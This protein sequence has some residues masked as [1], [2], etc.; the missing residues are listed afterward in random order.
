MTDSINANVVVSMPSQLFTMARSFKAVANGKIYIGKIDTDPVNPENQIPV[1]V[2]NEDGSHVPVS[3]PI[4]INAAGYPV[5][6]GQI[7]KF[8]TV[9]G[10]SMAVYDAYGA[11]QFY[12]PNVLKYDPDQFR[13]IIESPEGAGH[14]GY[15]YRRNTGSTMRMVSD[16]LDERVSLWDFHC[17]S[18]GNVIQP[19]PTVDSR[20][21]IQKAIDA[22]YEDGGGT[23]IIPTGTWYL[24]SYG[25]PDKISNY[26][27]VIHWR[28]R[29]NIHFEAG[30]TLKLTNYFN[31]RGYCVICGFDG[32]D[33]ATSGDLRDAMITG[34]GTIHC[35]DN[36][37]AVGGS[38][39]YAIGTGRS[40]NVS[41]RDIHI[42]GGD[43]TWAVTLGWNGYGNNTVVD[44]VTVTEV[45]KTEVARNVDQ[46]LFYVG[47][48]F[49]GVQNCYMKPSESG[50][51]AKI[52][53]AVEL[54]QS[55]T[56]CLNNQMYGFMRGVYVVLHGRETA[57]SGLFMNNIRVSGNTAYINGQFVTVGADS[58]D[59]DTHVS[60]VIISDNICTI[61][62]PVDSAPLVRCFIS[63]DLFVEAPPDNETAR[64]LVDG[65]IFLAPTTTPDSLFFF[66]RVSSRGFYFS[67]NMCD[68]RR[69]ISGD[70]A[71]TGI[72]ELRDIIW[73]ASNKIG[74]TWIGQRGGNANMFEFYVANI[75]RCKFEIS[76]PYGDTSMAS[77]FYAP[78]TANITFTVVKVDPE[79]I[80]SSV[81]AVS[82]SEAN[83]NRGTNYFEFPETIS[84]SSFNTAGAVFCYSTSTNY[85]WCGSATALSKSGVSGLVTPGEYGVKDNGQLG[86]VGYND[87]GAARNWSQR[88]LLKSAI[89]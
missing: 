68:C 79:N 4:I 69:I 71:G 16:V 63:S 88:V 76:M 64:V 49:S 40:Y 61:M 80:P 11:Q 72:V 53:A 14:V 26:G 30:S 87:T 55:G 9:Q 15:Q 43:L 27:G 17:D 59:F 8:V 29:V 18:S 81:T 62:N 85:A 22:I 35:G 77:I 38:L 28:S 52:S 60:D 86:G 5:Y 66:Y 41:V 6:N 46:S 36:I 37:Q 20:Q 24:N 33:P 78:D 1:Y 83:K 7:A 12:F 48:Q 73:D 56:F 45:K 2:E 74:P 21:Y 31:E 47:C 32:N 65:N 10:H 42:T 57:G 67:N 54:H 50:L 75:L 44:G 84:F 58:I 89:E 25:V 23:L 39:A 19:G 51:A 82:I 3:Q 13:A 34:N 70:G